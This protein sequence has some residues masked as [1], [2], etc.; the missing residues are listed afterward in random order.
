MAQ[1]SSRFG[2]IV[3]AIGA[4]VGLGNIYRFPLVVHNDGGGAYILAYILTTIVFGIPL[5]IVEVSGGRYS[6]AD[7]VSTFEHW[8]QGIFGWIIAV[9]ATLILSYYFVIMSWIL[10]FIFISIQGFS[11]TFGDLTST[12]Y[13]VIFFVISVLLSGVIVSFNVE[14]GI[15]KV[16]KVLIPFIFIVMLVLLAFVATLPKFGEGVSMFITPDFSVLKSPSIWMAVF[17]Q[18]FFSLALGHGELLT[19]GSY[20]DEDVSIP[21]ASI[22]I[23]F[24]NFSAAIIMGLIIFP[25]LAQ[26]GGPGMSQ[27]V[28]RDFAFKTFPKLFTNMPYGNILGIV[29]FVLLFVGSLSTSIA[30]LNVGSSVSIGKGVSRRRA[31]ALTTVIVLILG[32]PSALSYSA[33]DIQ[34]FG[35]PFLD[36]MDFSTGNYLLPVAAMLTA[37]GFTWLPEKRPVQNDVIY[38]IVKY[39]LPAGIILMIV[40]NI[41]EV[42]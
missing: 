14:D 35:V 9:T 6:G 42:I 12:H 1:W 38:Y 19:Y 7:V 8:N 18:A 29:F 33:M 3:A 5:M 17:G 23:T 22:I 15:E 11:Y 21:K 16:S 13:P 30:L 32:I 28:G 26:F 24:F 39:L 41:S 31:S 20:L 36:L 37:V 34:L 25:I 40:V 2:F 4:A 27:K 10:A